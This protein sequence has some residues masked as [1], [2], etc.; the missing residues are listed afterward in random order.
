MKKIMMTLAAVAVAATMNAQVYVGGTLGLNFQ[1]KLAN[2]E[3]GDDA[4][5][6][7]FSIR[8]EIGYMLNEDMGVGIALG[9]G[10]NTNSKADLQDELKGWNS[11]NAGAGTKYKNSQI[12]FE[13]APYF[14]YNF[15]K[16]EKV[17]FFFDAGVGFG[18]ISQ[19][20]SDDY[21]WSATRFSIFVQPG[22]A[23]NLN[24]KVSFVAKLGDGLGFRS[25]KVK[26]H[27]AQSTFGLDLKSL[28][29]LQ[30]GLYYNF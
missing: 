11:I 26:D 1:N 24:E 2:Q 9:F 23:V 4:T 30:F 22:V 18:Y 12:A 3:N 28:A 19:K 14:R 5:G 20:Q 29:G 8:P 6:M 17:N 15:V 10:V 21:T 7:T 27:D 25:T 16:L 13:V